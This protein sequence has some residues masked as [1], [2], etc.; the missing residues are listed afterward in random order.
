MANYNFWG[1]LK[2]IATPLIACNAFAMCSDVL[3]SL[4]YI[5]ITSSVSYLFLAIIFSVWLFLYLHSSSNKNRL[6]TEIDY[7]EEKTLQTFGDDF[8]KKNNLDIIRLHVRYWIIFNEFRVKMYNA[9]K[10]NKNQNDIHNF[11]IKNIRYE[12]KYN[13]AKCAK[14][15]VIKL[16]NNFIKRFKQA[17]HDDLRKTSVVGDERKYFIISDDNF[18]QPHFLKVLFGKE[19][20]FEDKF[21]ESF[22]KREKYLINSDIFLR[23][24][25]FIAGANIVV[26]A[27]TM[28][29]GAHGVLRS[30]S[31]IFGPNIL[32]I[33]ENA[34]G[35][36]FFLAGGIA[37]YMLTYPMIQNFGR[38]FELILQDFS[39]SL[40]S[41]K[42]HNVMAVIMAFF[43]AIGS[44]IFTLYNS[45]IPAMLPVNLAGLASYAKIFTAIVAFLSVF[46]L[47]FVSVSSKFQ[48]WFSKSQNSKSNF[49]KTML[50]GLVIFLLFLIDYL[51]LPKMFFGYVEIL[52]AFAF[53]FSNW[54]QNG[55]FL[56]I[57]M[58]G[59]IAFSATSFHQFSI[60]FQPTLLSS[61]FIFVE[62]L[63]QFSTFTV[64]FYYGLN[65]FFESHSSDSRVDVLYKA[66]P[67]EEIKRVD[68]CWSITSKAVGSTD[69]PEVSPNSVIQDIRN[70]KNSSI[71]KN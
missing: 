43:T 38:K 55:L 19:I 51:Y 34:V 70:V 35:I 28:F 65:K 40:K 47:Y 69:N 67:T 9:F 26:N 16:L 15:E 48:E 37:S 68:S 58:I 8:S 57:A 11:I 7:Y 18:K 45:P 42:W 2:L 66:I 21:F 29:G 22:S 31:Q 50:F 36:L 32:L 14:K 23:I 12:E 46:S 5:G 25:T 60:L 4:A 52:G 17:Y 39:Y 1:V 59:A 13:L 41:F 64:T 63:F 53:C 27:L 30:L 33:N 20:P 6:T 10:R 3:P 44:A 71:V 54:G 49:K 24:I 56:V 61:I 62:L